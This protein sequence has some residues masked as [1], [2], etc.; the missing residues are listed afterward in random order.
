MKIRSGFTFLT[1]CSPSKEAWISLIVIRLKD[2]T[3]QEICICWF[4]LQ[5][6]FREGCV[7]STGCG[8]DF[9]I[10]KNWQFETSFWIIVERFLYS[11]DI[12]SCNR[13]RTPKGNLESLRVGW[14][15]VRSGCRNSDILLFLRKFSI[16]LNVSKFGMVDGKFFWNKSCLNLLC[17]D[18]LQ[19]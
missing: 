19:H 8:E 10:L 11:L 7:T 15:D 17:N 13:L 5:T 14:E 3:W 6:K 2:W 4:A 18:N 1:F 16:T 9:M 12:Q